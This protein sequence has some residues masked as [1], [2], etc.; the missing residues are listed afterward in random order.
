MNRV[1]TFLV[2]PLAPLVCLLITASVA[3][4]AAY[5]LSQYF[6]ESVSFPR[7][8]SR[9]SLAIL[10]LSILPLSRSFQLGVA[11]LG[12][13]PKVST[14]LI[15]FL[16]GFIIGLII[17]GFVIVI[18]IALDIRTVYTPLFD[19]PGR[20]TETLLS[21]IRS[22]VLVSVLEESLFRGLL[23]GIL[24]KY[25][26]VR[27]AVS[28]TGVYYAGL[29]FVRGA[30]KIDADETT[31]SSGFEIIPDAALQIFQM[32]NFD[33][34]L[35]LFFVNVFLC[36][37]RLYTR[38]GIGYC[39][40]LHASWVSLIKFTNAFSYVEPE[41]YWGFLVSQYDGI[42]G[43]LVAAWLA[44]L[45]AGFLFFIHARSGTSKDASTL[46]TKTVE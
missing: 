22:G 33:T 37:L 23:L 13:A 17:L 43:Y 39:I 2:L 35:A 11:G 21:A 26:T 45:S 14:I 29:H 19:I 25:G 16:I 4:L 34:F 9:L 32:S 6:F 36:C 5:P 12:L 46:M 10:A 40:G 3:A 42:I 18:T 24:L 31:W 8:V 28:I 1:L 15:Q 44:L 20:I 27:S 7:I 30:G 38:T 41:A